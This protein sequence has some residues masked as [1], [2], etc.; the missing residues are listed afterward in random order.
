MNLRLQTQSQARLEIPS[1]QD[2]EAGLDEGESELA[3]AQPTVVCE[4]YG[5]KVTNKEAPKLLVSTYYASYH[6]VVML[7][8]VQWYIAICG[9][10]G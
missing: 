4:A 5:F 2:A 3:P 9:M 6:L 1:T 7:F 10:C 8:F